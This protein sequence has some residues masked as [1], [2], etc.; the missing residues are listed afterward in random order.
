VTGRTPNETILLLTIQLATP[1]VSGL[2][3]IVGALREWQVDRSPIQLHPGDIGWFWRFGALQTAAALRT[4]RR[5][6][7][8]VAVGLQDGPRLLRLAISPEAHQDAE[9]AQELV[10]GVTRFERG[11]LPEGTVHIEAPMGSLFRNLL[12]EHG[13]APD[14]LWTPLRRDLTGPI[15]IS[16]FA[17]EVIDSANAHVRVAV[18]RAA[19]DNSTFTVERWRSMAAGLPYSDARCLVACDKSQAAVAAVTVWSAGPGKPGLIEPLGVH[20][21]HR[22]RGFGAVITV[23]AAAALQAMGASSAI[24]CTPSANAGAVATYK[25]AGFQE[26]PQ[27]RDLTRPTHD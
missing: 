26:L 1:D 13:W 6:G 23:A 18:Q 25:S 27:M 5:N 19:F 11:V 20:R 17:V 2:G 12:S 4:W 24:V 7:C 9:L 8:I 3:E 15:E 21:E 10:D 16:S 22:R 14:E